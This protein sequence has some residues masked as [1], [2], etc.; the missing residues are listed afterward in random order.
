MSPVRPLALLVLLAGCGDTGSGTLQLGW[1]F[2]DGR[3][4]TE[5][6][7][8]TVVIGP[9]VGQQAST[10]SF[11]CLDGTA[12]S[13]AM[14]PGVPRDTTITLSAVSPAGDELYRGTLLTDDALQPTTVTL[15]ATG[16]R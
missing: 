1:Q 6:G 13:S 7:A 10:A 15:Y 11:A 4:C 3:R 5:A 16:A 12:P 14:V 8:S 9:V 2:A